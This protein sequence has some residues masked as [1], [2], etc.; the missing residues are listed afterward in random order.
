MIAGPSSSGKTT[1]SQRLSIQLA[2]HG[3]NPHTI[4]VD[5]YFKNREE[6]PLDEFGKRIMNVWRLLTSTGL[7]GI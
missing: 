5:N 6:T 7:T 2:A 4:A 1:F 3:M